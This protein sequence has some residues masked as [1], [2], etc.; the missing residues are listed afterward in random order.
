MTRRENL[1]RGLLLAAGILILDQ[2]VKYAMYVYLILGFRPSVEVTSFFN[3]VVVWNY[4][5]SFGMFNSGS[6]EAAY[7][8]VGLAAAIVAV[9]G[10]W[11][12]KAENGL[13]LTA[14]GLVIGGAIGNVV[15]RLRYGAVFDF[16]DFHAFGWHWP[17]F[18]VADA[19][20]TCGV[21]C[22]FWDAFVGSRKSGK[23]GA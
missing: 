22:L 18:N 13:I 21:A 9:L 15:D 8:F 12:A 10:V 4:G 23:M 11:L 3:L 7:I 17:A 14:L 2:A 19:A 1:K 16:L 5:V 6:S 20:I